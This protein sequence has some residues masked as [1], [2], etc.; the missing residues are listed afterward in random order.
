MMLMIIIKQGNHHDSDCD[1]DN[2]GDD[3]EG[4]LFIDGKS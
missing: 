4:D 1:D 2:K 3:H